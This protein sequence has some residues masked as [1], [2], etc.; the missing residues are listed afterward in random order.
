MNNSGDGGLIVLALVA[1]VP[2]YLLIER[3]I[4]FWLVFVPIAV[5]CIVSFIAWLKR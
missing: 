4:F 3:P 5:C 2:I 1:G